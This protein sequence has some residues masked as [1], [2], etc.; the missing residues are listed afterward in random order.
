MFEW[1]QL[2]FVFPVGISI[3]IV[4][5]AYIV[6]VVWTLH[7]SKD[8]GSSLSF[9]SAGSLVAGTLVYFVSG[10]VVV[11]IAVLAV[12]LPLMLM[13]FARIERSEEMELLRRENKIYDKWWWD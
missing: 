9:S 10:S 7:L 8:P 3:G 12:L 5:L 2:P 11:G 4:A 13:L 1:M 6:S